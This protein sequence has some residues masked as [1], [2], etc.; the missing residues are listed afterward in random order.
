MRETVIFVLVLSFVFCIG[1]YQIGYYQGYKHGELIGHQNEL[2]D[3]YTK[4]GACPITNGGWT[5][6]CDGSVYK[7]SIE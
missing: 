5:R 6:D 4:W 1:Y 7:N 3:L 2:N